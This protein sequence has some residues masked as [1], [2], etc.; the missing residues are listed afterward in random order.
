MN[1]K[2]KECSIELT[3]ETKHFYKK[4]GVQY[5]RKECRECFLKKQRAKRA[6]N[7][8][9]KEKLEEVHHKGMSCIPQYSNCQDKSCNA[10]LDKDKRYFKVLK[11]KGKADK[12]V[13]SSL[14]KSCKSA[15]I[16][17]KKKAKY[18]SMPKIEK[19]K[20][21]KKPS[22]KYCADKRCN[23]LLTI[24][25]CYSSKRVRQDGSEAIS[26]FS[27][28]KSCTHRKEREKRAMK[29]KKVLTK[30]KRLLK[31]KKKK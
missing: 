2:N 30:K 8:P 31:L 9:V 13:S 23:V 5:F 4:D 28:C 10:L 19:V 17:E 24:D 20:T 22:T 26:L 3:D 6:A 18:D 7:N 29:A 11:Y 1:C 12:L 14:C 16:K 21:Y 25:N 15:D 27:I